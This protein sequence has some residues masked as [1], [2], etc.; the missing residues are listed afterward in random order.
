MSSR[1]ARFVTRWRPQARTSIDGNRK[2][3]KRYRRQPKLS[4]S[5][6]SKTQIYVH[7]MRNESPYSKR[8]SSLRDEYEGRGVVLDEIS[9]VLLEW[10]Q[11]RILCLRRYFNTAFGVRTCSRKR[12]Q[13]GIRLQALSDFSTAC[14]EMRLF[15]VA[16]PKDASAMQPYDTVFSR[17]PIVI[18]LSSQLRN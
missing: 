8:I 15:Y 1:F 6:Y 14:F 10:I 18:H 7:Y 9:R 4:W 17:L 5:I 3:Y 12:Y 11:R 16:I 2:Q 13:P